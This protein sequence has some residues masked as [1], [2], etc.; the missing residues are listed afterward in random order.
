[1]ER[2]AVHREITDL[3]W[4]DRKTEW[5]LFYFVCAMSCKLSND[6]RLMLW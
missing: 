5:H 6:L 4:K 2:L 3:E 1:M